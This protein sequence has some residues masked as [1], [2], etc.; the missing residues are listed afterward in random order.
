M[1]VVITGASRGIGRAISEK[2]AENGHDLAICSRHKANIEP[3]FNELKGRY[4]DMHLL[5]A[6]ADLG[7]EEE[8]QQFASQINKSWGDLDVLILN[9][10]SYVHGGLTDPDIDILEK[11]LRTNLFSAYYLT[12]GVVD[13]MKKKKKGTIILLSS[14][15]GMKAYAGGGAYSV[16][17]FAVTGLAHNL[18][19]ELKPFHIGVTCILPGAVLTDSWGGTTLPEERFISPQEVADTVYNIAMLSSRTVIEDIVIRPMLGDI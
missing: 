4:P 8:A 5:A 18:R 10:G 14:V 19:E 12:R 16:S 9:A 1:K 3:Y 13:L 2:F 7:I 11:Q 15:A 6:Q 17:K